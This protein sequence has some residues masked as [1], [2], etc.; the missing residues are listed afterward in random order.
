MARP[1]TTSLYTTKAVIILDNEGKRLLSKYYQSEYATSKEQKAFEKSLFD[2]TKKTT[3]E[4]IMFD[5]QIVVYKNSIDVFLYVLGSA[6]ENELILNHVLNSFY[7]ALSLLLK[8]QVEKRVMM[9]NFDL[10]ALALDETVDGGIIL[11]SEPSLI[12]SRVTKKSSEADMP[13]SE[14]TVA[15][16]FQRAQ[17]QLARSL[18][19]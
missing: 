3:S 7:E 1:Q 6:D 19:K 12:A 10:V 17:E 9:E 11:E 5:N 14:Q 13:L 15:Q 8:G 4:I 16:V 2:K 18:L